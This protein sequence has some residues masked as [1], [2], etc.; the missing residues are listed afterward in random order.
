MEDSVKQLEEASYQ[1]TIELKELTHMMAIMNRKMDQLLDKS[2]VVVVSTKVGG[3]I[4]T[5][6]IRGFPLT[7][8]IPKPSFLNWNFQLLKG[9]ILWEG[10]ASAKCFFFFFLKY[11]AELES[12]KVGIASIQL[13]GK[14]FD[15]FQDYKASA[16]DLNWKTFEVDITT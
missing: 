14:A 8:C 11:N 7:P 4:L 10:C 3:V 5:K 15:W 2:M 12:E 9:K 13:E 16:K 1:P 6:L